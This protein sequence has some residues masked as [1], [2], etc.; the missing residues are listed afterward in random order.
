MTVPKMPMTKRDEVRLDKAIRAFFSGGQTM[1]DLTKA[2]ADIFGPEKAQEIAVTETTRAYSE[3]G[4]A[5]ADRLRDEG[6]EILEIWNTTNDELVCE[7]CD[8]NGVKRGEGWTDYPPV[9]PG[10]RC[11]VGTEIA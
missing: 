1:G 11:S 3:A 9:H 8:L 10:C 2:V 6:F 7:L 4:R 5:A